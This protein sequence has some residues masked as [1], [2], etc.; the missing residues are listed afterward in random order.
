MYDVIVLGAGPAGLTAALYTA[1]AKLKTLVV[2]GPMV[3]GQIA[4]TYQVDN[5]PG[6]PEGITGPELADKFKAHAER[7]GAEFL[8]GDAT[9]VDFSTTPYR[10]SMGDKLLEA[11]S[12]IVA[13]GMTHK[14][15]GVPGEDRLM[16]RGVFVCATCD[17][18]LY[19]D[20]KAIVV[21]GGDSAIQEAIDLARFASEVTIV[22]HREEARACRCLMDKAENDPK[23]KILYNT[24]VTEILG[25]KR[26]KQVILRDLKT[27]A[28][29][30][31]DT[32]GVLLAIGWD[33][34]T[35]I[36]RGQL[37]MDGEG[38]LKTEGVKTGKPGIFVAGDLMDKLYRQVVT[39]CGNGCAAA[40]EAIHWVEGQR[41]E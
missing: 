30:L 24:E 3:G 41:G 6:F 39:S 27:G 33:P 16:G 40:L 32:D 22:H 34:N 38:Y 28:S 20:R 31:V 17:A 1:R 26:V 2:T 11:K 19:E 37:D 35:A 18:V 15:L 8:D 9:G 23:I 12:V 29:R 10:V 25:D 13:T 21:G 5:Y 4:F 7:F 14:K 36:F